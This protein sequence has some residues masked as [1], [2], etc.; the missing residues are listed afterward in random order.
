MAELAASWRPGPVT[1]HD[2]LPPGP[3]AALAAVLDQPH[4]PTATMP[5]L[6]HWLH[7][8][9]W[10]P[11]SELGV[12]GHPADGYFLPPLANRR[13]MWAGGR[14]TFSAPLR[15]GVPAVR[16]RSVTAVDVKH[17]TSGELL[18]ITV[19]AEIAQE[20]EVV[21]VDEQDIV[22]RSGP[23]SAPTI[24]IDTDAVPDAV[25]E[26][27]QRFVA[28]SSLLF[29]FSALTA[30]AHRIHYD[31]PYATEVEGYPGLVVHG[32]LLALSMAELVRR[33]VPD[34][35]LAAF[36]YRFRHPV[37]DGEHLLVSGTPG[38]PTE[39]VVGT[40]RQPRAAVATVTF[41]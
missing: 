39:L 12:D 29:R 3:S 14:L 9:E 38:T 7:F 15:I 33:E 36:T 16:T 19:R 35:P 26:W 18:F 5:P 24:T 27:R 25:G 6:W 17:G 30:N 40:A 41:R 4:A 21:V 37:F 10:P 23:T 32:P 13:R 28:D 22:Y 31:R 8:L 34:Q 11:R 2:S 1:D 20:G